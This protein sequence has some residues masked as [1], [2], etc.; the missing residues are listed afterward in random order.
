MLLRRI[1]EDKS[2]KSY[3][4]IKNNG[5]REICDYFYHCIFCSL[6][7]NKNK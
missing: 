7:H 2:L 1:G 3:N 5:K 4:P 6:F